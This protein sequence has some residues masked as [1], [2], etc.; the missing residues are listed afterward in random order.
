MSVEIVCSWEV[1]MFI[2]EVEGNEYMV[3]NE[4][5]DVDITA[6]PSGEV[7]KEEHPLFQQIYDE[8]VG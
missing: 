1:E 4:G 8:V 6:M 2:V 7:L 3:K 5:G